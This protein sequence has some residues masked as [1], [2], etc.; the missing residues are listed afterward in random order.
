[1]QPV[2]TARPPSASAGRGARAELRGVRRRYGRQ[3]VLAGVDAVF[4]PGRLTAVTGPS[5]SGR[6]TLLRLAAG[7]DVPDA[8]EVAVD[9]V[10]VSAL[11]REDRAAFR[12]RTTGFV[13]QTAGTAFLSARENVE[14]GLAV[15]GLPEDGDL[16]EEALAAAGS[17]REGRRWSAR[18]TTRS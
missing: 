11:T 12:A 14:L 6:S 17:P 15:R 1:M 8:G 13:G 5:G 16:V 2:V 18:R 10:V 9:G 4:A 7:L 3:T